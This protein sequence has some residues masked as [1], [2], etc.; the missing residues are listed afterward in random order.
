MDKLAV[1]Y[2]K[3]DMTDPAA[4][5]A[6]EEHRIARLERLWLHRR[7]THRCIAAV[8]RGKRIL[9]SVLNR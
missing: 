6:L 8:V 3:A 5:I 7:G 2:I 1:A 4:P 9:A